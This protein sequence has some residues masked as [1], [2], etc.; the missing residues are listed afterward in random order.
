MDGINKKL[1]T[2]NIHEI[3]IFESFDIGESTIHSYVRKKVQKIKESLYQANISLLKKTVNV[4]PIEIFV[5][6]L[7]LKLI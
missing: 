1:M 4:I 5:Y 7:K 6:S 3:L 2:I